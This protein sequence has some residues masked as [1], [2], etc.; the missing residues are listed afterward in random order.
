MWR[1]LSLYL[2]NNVLLTLTGS[3]S[4]GLRCKKQKAPPHISMMTAGGED[5]RYYRDKITSLLDNGTSLL[6][7][8]IG[9]PLLEAFTTNQTANI[10][11]LAIQ[12]LEGFGFK[13][14]LLRL[15]RGVNVKCC[16]TWKEYDC[17]CTRGDG[18]FLEWI[19][20]IDPRES[21]SEWFIIRTDRFMR[22][23]RFW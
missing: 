20:K 16:C 21:W 4:P 9:Y 3:W 12:R 7:K 6:D 18:I 2:A 8:E 17:R 14:H 19:V 13:V 5:G 23:F 1:Y 10:E 22:M 11:A 15:S